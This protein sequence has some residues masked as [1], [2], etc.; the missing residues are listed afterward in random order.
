VPTA[1]GGVLQLG[2]RP[3]VMGIVNVTPDSF[4]DG[5]S[6]LLDPAQAVDAALRMES[7]GAD[8]VDV[9]GEST[10]PGA[11][12][13]AK[14]E[15]LARVL[16]VIRGLAG[17]LTI[18]I[19]IDTYKADVAR[20][21][22][23]AGASMV[24]D[25]SG[26]HRDPELAPVVAEKGAA[27]V[28]MHSRGTPATMAELAIYGDLVAEVVAE[29]SASVGLA[30]ASGVP[31]GQILVDPGIGFAKRPEHS[32]GVL[33]R[34]PELAAGLG[35]P[36]LV[37]ASRKS[38]LRAPLHDRPPSERDWGTAAAVTAAVLAGAHIVRVHAVGEM[39]QVVRVAEAI[40][41]HG[42]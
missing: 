38:F 19:S 35:R 39:V 12:A 6:R 23:D 14:E 27:I 5:G 16:P 2:E 28:L 37:G 9:G 31:P 7:D 25:V 4:A 21:A 41:R 11:A 15:E 1:H 34:L 36:I 24:N 20:A 32:Y 42:C 26:L 13:L 17:R 40:R 30:T 10:R 3:L 33:A 18:P 8:L 22:L 29:L